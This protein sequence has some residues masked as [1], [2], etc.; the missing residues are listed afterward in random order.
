MDDV[1]K[2]IA[3]LLAGFAGYVT[4]QQFKLGREKFKL[5]LFEKR[6]SVFAAVRKFLSQLATEGQVSIAQ[7]LQVQASVAEASFLFESDI[8][9]YLAEIAKR[10]LRMHAVQAKLKVASSGDDRSRLLEDDAAES[11]WIADQ[12]SLLESKFAPYLKFHVW[13]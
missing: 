10:A 13:R 1:W 6:F 7:V 8:N 4:Y 12:L 3:L 5:D 11:T 2:L 9:D